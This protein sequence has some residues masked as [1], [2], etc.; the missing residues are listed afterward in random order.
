MN[1]DGDANIDAGGILE[2]K[3][4][5]LSFPYIISEGGTI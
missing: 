2:K 5:L 3:D 4:K 1:K